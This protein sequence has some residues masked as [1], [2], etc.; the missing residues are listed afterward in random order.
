MMEE[1]PTPQSQEN[2]TLKL[3]DIPTYEL[4]DAPTLEVYEPEALYETCPT[5]ACPTTEGAS[6]WDRRQLTW[7]L[8]EKAKNGDS[9]EALGQALKFEADTNANVAENIGWV[10][11]YWMREHLTKVDPNDLKQ[12]LV[13]YLHLANARPS[14]LHS[15]MLSMAV[16]TADRAPVFDMFGFFEL[17][18]PSNLRDEDYEDGKADDGKTFPS[19]AKRVIDRIIRSGAVVTVQ[20]LRPLFRQD[21]ISDIDLKSALYFFVVLN[22]QRCLKLQHVDKAWD[23]IRIYL[24]NQRADAPDEVDSTILRLGCKA[25]D[26]AHLDSVPWFFDSWD[27]TK[28]RQMDF[29]TIK[30]SAGIPLP[31]TVSMATG[32]MYRFAKKAVGAKQAVDLTGMIDMMYDLAVKSR[33]PAWTWYRRA[34]LLDW[35]GRRDEALTSMK[36]LYNSMKKHSR[37]WLFLAELIDDTKLKCG[38]LAMAISIKPDSDGV[39]MAHY[40]IGKAFFS[41]GD[42]ERAAAEFAQALRIIHHSHGQ[43]TFVLSNINGMVGDIKRA[44]AHEEF[45][46]YANMRDNIIG[47]LQSD[48]K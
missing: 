43:F 47:Y 11:F 13:S 1:K 25:V 10:L 6:D 48:N 44:N 45:P 9:H 33:F 40:R 3:D 31:S 2:P 32:C 20:S 41:A 16:K 7:L 24:D 38:C 19:L 36:K 18:G 35:S 14:M 12:V 8:R 28:S 17:W 26:S 4:D 39:A 42:K 15:T 37:Y 22:I 5:T 21:K 34:K 30:N 23:A 46:Y 27:L 29:E